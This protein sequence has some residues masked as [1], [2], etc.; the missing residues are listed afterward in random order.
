MSRRALLV[1]DAGADQV[2][3]VARPFLKRDHVILAEHHAELLGELLV[4]RVGDPQHAEQVLV[5]RIDLG[6]LMDMDDVFQRE[7]M[8]LKDLGD[9]PQLVFAAQADDVD[10]HDGPVAEQVPCSSCGSSMSCSMTRSLSVRHDADGR[11]RGVGRDRERARLGAGRRL[12]ANP[13]LEPAASAALVGHG[14]DCNRCEV[15]GVRCQGVRFGGSE[16][17]GRRSEVRGRRRRSEVGGRRSGFR[18]QGSESLSK[19]AF[20]SA[21]FF[22][23]LVR[24][25]SI[26]FASPRDRKSL[27]GPRFVGA[28]GATLSG[29][30]PGGGTKSSAGE[31]KPGTRAWSGALFSA[32]A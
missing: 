8:D 27:D 23:F 9:R 26:D 2:E 15:S 4:G 1:P 3:A 10:P 13:R 25:Y 24:R 30:R 20:A 28:G 21:N 7:R 16:V 18:D 6:P 22:F 17:G 5:V 29:F 11:R 14:G 19:V 32:E 12:L 31:A